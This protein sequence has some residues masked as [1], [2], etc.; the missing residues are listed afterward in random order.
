MNKILI[1]VY[2]PSLAKEFEIFICES[3]KMHEALPLISKAIEKISDEEYRSSGKEVLCT[4]K[5]GN[6]IDINFS[7]CELGIHN[8]ALLILI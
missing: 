2:V 5:E 8:G 4:K 6:I 3:Q 1:R 7:A